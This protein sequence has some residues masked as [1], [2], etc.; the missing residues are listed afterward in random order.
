VFAFPLTV[1][2]NLLPVKSAHNCSHNHTNQKFLKFFELNFGKIFKNLIFEMKYV[3]CSLFNEFVR[4]L[5]L[6]WHEWAI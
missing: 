2:E 3:V 6:F 1:D 4:K 5:G